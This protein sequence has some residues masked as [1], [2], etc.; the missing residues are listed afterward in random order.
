MPVHGPVTHIGQPCFV[1]VFVFVH[2][3]N[4]ASSA[5]RNVAPVCDRHS[6]GEDVW[7]VGRTAPH[8]LYSALNEG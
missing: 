4:F 1:C 7:G 6:A 8:I 5:D 2:L 3:C